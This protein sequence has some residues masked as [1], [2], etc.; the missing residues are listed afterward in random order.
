MWIKWAVVTAERYGLELED[1]H[2]Y[3]RVFPSVP[4]PGIAHIVLR[5]TIPWL[6][7]PGRLVLHRERASVRPAVLMAAPPGAQPTPPG[8]LPFREHGARLEITD[9]LLA[10]WSTNSWMGGLANF[11]IDAFCA[12]AAA[13]IGAWQPRPTAVLHA[14]FD[15]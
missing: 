2:A 11:A 10:V 1:P 14:C 5:G 6:G 13:V 12:A 7:V 4:V 8:G 15:H 3:H 9:D